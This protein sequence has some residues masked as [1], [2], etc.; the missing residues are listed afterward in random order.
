MK[1]EN[2]TLVILQIKLNESNLKWLK[3]EI[4]IISHIIVLHNILERDLKLRRTYIF[5]MNNTFK[6][7][8]NYP[9]HNFYLKYLSPRLYLQY[10]LKLNKF[11]K[12]KA[13]IT[14]EFEKT[15]CVL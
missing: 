10:H 1:L 2:S 14:C 12:V 4:F 5:I 15:Q 13:N 9:N 7:K 3:I 8:Y 6:R 11:K